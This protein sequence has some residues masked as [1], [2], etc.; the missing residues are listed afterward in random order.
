MLTFALKSNRYPLVAALA[1]LFYGERG[2]TSASLR[3]AGTQ[4]TL[5][6]L[7]IARCARFSR[8]RTYG[9]SWRAD[10]ATRALELLRTTTGAR[11]FCD[12]G[13]PIREEP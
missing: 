11:G 8:R 10:V 6:G 4:L 1:A 7:M 9:E 13:L 12:F 2:G 5:R 3:C